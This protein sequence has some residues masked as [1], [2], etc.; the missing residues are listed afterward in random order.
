MAVTAEMIT[1][2][3]GTA[4]V[5]STGVDAAVILAPGETR[6]MLVGTVNRPS[7]FIDALV[8][9]GKVT[10]GASTGPLSV[11]LAA[12]EII[13]DKDHSSYLP[14]TL[15]DMHSTVGYKAAQRN[16]FWSDIRA[17]V[18]Y[19]NPVLDT[20]AEFVEAGVDMTQEMNTIYNPQVG[21][22]SVDFTLS[23]LGVVGVAASKTIQGVLFEAVTAGAAGNDITVEFTDPGA[24]NA[25]TTF[26]VSGTAIMVVLASDGTDI[27]ATATSLVADFADAPSTVTDLITVSGTGTD[28]LVEAAAVNMTGG[29]TQGDFYT[30]TTTRSGVAVPA[31]IGGTT[32]KGAGE[33]VLGRQSNYFTVLLKD[34]V[35][36]KTA[37]FKSVDP[38]NS[39][40]ELV[41]STGTVG[42]LAVA[43]VA[44]P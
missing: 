12:G 30:L 25:T 20:Q 18:E 19:A 11:K 38:I 31:T 10:R 5:V 9:A 21:A 17:R 28:S 40:W 42:S 32:I 44:T 27:T 8:S 7:S 37:L 2:T 43:S 29:V 35:S 3:A 16:D 36:L 34:G 24:I 15:A 4:L 6:E 23:G 1:N 26:S 22:T 39:A 13:L 41:S 14:E 33:L